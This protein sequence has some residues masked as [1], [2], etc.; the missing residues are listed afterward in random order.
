MCDVAGFGFLMITP[1]KAKLRLSRFDR[2][3]D[4]SDIKL[5]CLACSV[6]PLVYTNL[7]HLVNS[8]SNLAVEIA[9]IDRTGYQNPSRD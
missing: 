5:S 7:G 6:R 4:N 1:D 9:T 3:K 2:A 8:R